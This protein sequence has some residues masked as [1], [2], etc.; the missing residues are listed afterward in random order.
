VF[1]PA[2][3]QDSGGVCP[4]SSGGPVCRAPHRGPRCSV[5]AILAGHRQGD[6]SA[7]WGDPEALIG[8]SVWRERGDT[9]A[10]IDPDERVLIPGHESTRD[11]REGAVSGNGELYRSAG[12]LPHAVDHGNGCSAHTEPIDVERHCPER[13]AS[14]ED[15]M[16]CGNVPR[17]R[18]GQERA[19]LAGLERLHH[20]ARGLSGPSQCT[21]ENRLTTRQ[22]AHSTMDGLLA[23][24]GRHGFGGAAGGQDRRQPGRGIS[25]GDSIFG[26]PVDS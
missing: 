10:T 17:I 24:Q 22:K 4:R 6:L 9:P 23:L 18:A 5:A 25:E 12:L 7:P 26:S 8:A 20:D 19:P 15:E 11:I 14:G 1:R 21:E 3:R 2:P 16:P 13:V